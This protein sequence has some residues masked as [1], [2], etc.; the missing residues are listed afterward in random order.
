MILT[1]RNFNTSFYD[2]AGGGDPVL[3]QHL[4]WFF[5]HPEVYILIIPGFGIVSHVISTFSG[6]SIFGYIG[7]VY[8]IISIGLLGFIVWSFYN[9][10]FSI[11]N[12]MA[13]LCSD[14]RVINFTIGWNVS[15]LLTTF[16][17]TNVNNY[18]QSAGNSIVRKRRS[19]ETIRESSFEKFRNSYQQTFNKPF[20]NN[21][22]WLN[23]LIGFIEGDGAI[24]EHKGRLRL[25]ITQKDPKV[26]FEI[27]NVLGFG[28]VKNFDKYSRFIVED[29]KNCF[30]IYLLLNGNLV[31]EHRINQ[32]YKWYFSLIN[33][34]RF[35]EEIPLFNPL[36]LSPSLKNSWI[37]G[38]TD[39]EGCFSINIYKNRR[40]GE[41]N[42]DIV[43]ARFILDQKNGQSV[44][45]QISELF[46]PVTVK[47]RGFPVKERA[48]ESD[49]NI[50]R[51][52]ISISDIENPNTKLIRNYF[53][54]YE[55]KTSK[56]NSFL[57]WCD[58]LDMFLGKQPLN[59]ETIV[60]IRTLNKLINK[61]TIEN[62]P[63]G[64]SKF[65]KV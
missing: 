48:T 18:N 47:L 34:P 49:R 6:K 9:L 2:P 63:T 57:I 58:V 29:T 13:F 5:G 7:M 38:F 17:S 41:K 32:I 26:L 24:L 43:R 56:H 27:Q 31:L 64:S 19:S 55:L 39:A 35:S 36:A 4:F 50:F 30:L 1:D 62:N 12:V 59:K 21:D 33:A 10:L 25:V 8:A 42:E 44:L 40:P 20:E 37:S 54:N 61:F 45:N 23:W 11:D 60:E 14:T 22:N 65:S 52:C 28:R 51:L 3:Y 16:Y 53:K 46:S 15:T